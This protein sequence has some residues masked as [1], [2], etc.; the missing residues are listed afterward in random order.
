MLMAICTLNS[1]T[2]Q[3]LECYNTDWLTD[4]LQYCMDGQICQYLTYKYVSKAAD[5]CVNKPKEYDPDKVKQIKSESEK[6]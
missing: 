3:K 2:S 1:V 6:N 4:N 5:G